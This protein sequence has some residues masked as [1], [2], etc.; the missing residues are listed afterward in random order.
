MLCRRS[1]G[2][3][4]SGASVVEIAFVMMFFIMILFGIVEY[5]RLLMVRHTMNAACREAARM[6]ATASTSSS[7]TITSADIQTRAFNVLG[8]MSGQFNPQL[9]SGSFVVYKY[10][11]ATEGSPYTTYTQTNFDADSTYKWT[12]ADFGDEIVVRLSG[13]YRTILPNVLFMPQN[14]TLTTKALVT[15]EANY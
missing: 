5:G 2:V 15:C 11:A 14:I 8:T 9:T 4:R 6:A 13:T 12:A 10:G 3:K 1:T 7:S